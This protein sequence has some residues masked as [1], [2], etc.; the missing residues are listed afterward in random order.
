MSGGYL[1]CDTDTCRVEYKVL[2]LFCARGFLRK[3]EV[4]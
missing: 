2:L 1:L 3:D 4:T